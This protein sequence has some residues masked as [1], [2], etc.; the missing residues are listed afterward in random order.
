M[1]TTIEAICADGY[2]LTPCDIQ[3]KVVIAVWFNT[4]PKTWR[5]EV[6]NNGWTNNETGLRWLQNLYTI[7]TNSRACGRFRLFILDSHGSYPTL[8]VNRIYAEVDIIPLYM[9]RILR[10]FYN[11]LILGVLLCLSACTVAS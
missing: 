2:S 9:P 10:I 5:F 7:S 6:S 4:L 3:L 8:K 1:V 11:R